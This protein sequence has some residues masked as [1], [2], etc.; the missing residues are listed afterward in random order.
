[1]FI[2]DISLP[3]FAGGLSS[4]DDES[5]DEDAFF[6]LFATTGVAAVFAFGFASSESLLSLLDDC[7]F[8]TVGLTLGLVVTGADG[9]FSFSSDESESDDDDDD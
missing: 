8:V 1:L 2:E 5:E 9:F 6:C 4:S 3:F 7:F